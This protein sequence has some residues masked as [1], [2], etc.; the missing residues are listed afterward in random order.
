MKKLQSLLRDKVPQ[1]SPE[2][3][4]A[5]HTGQKRAGD[6]SGVQA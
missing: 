6:E 4:P 3:S 2:K 1:A 5:G